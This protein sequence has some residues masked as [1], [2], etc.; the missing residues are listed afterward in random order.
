VYRILAAL[1][2][3]FLSTSDI[4]DRTKQ[5]NRELSSARL[6]QEIIELYSQNGISTH[7]FESVATWM[8]FGRHF[9]KAILGKKL[10]YPKNADTNPRASSIYN[11]MV[12]KA[13]SRFLEAVKSLRLQSTLIDGKHTLFWVIECFDGCEEKYRY[14]NLEKDQDFSNPSVWQGKMA[15]IREPIKKGGA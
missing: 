1:T 6:R 4:N 14:L 2:D 10:Q 15:A 13:G 12:E 9:F 3:I 8:M 7:I 5:I 11:T